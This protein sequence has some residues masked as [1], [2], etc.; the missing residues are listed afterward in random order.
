MDPLTEPARALAFTC[1]MPVWN[2]DDPDHFRAALDSLTRS[3]LRPTEVLIAVDGELAP[4][5][6]DVVREAQGAGARVSAN[7]GPRGLHHNLNQA[8]AGVRTPW[9]ARFDADDLNMP[10]R[11]QRQTDFLIDHP[12]VAVLG[13]AIVEFDE[14]GRDRIKAMPLSHEAIVRQARWRNPINHMSAFFR[15]GAVLDAGGYPALPRKE[16]YAL[17]LVLIARGERLANLVEPLVRARLG[18]NFHG[19][20][21]GLHNLSSEYALFRRKRRIA[22]IGAGP[23]LAALAALALRAGLLAFEGPAALVY[24]RALRR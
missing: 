9:V 14:A 17:W 11:F 6:A 15:T 2:G 1:L 13:G 20:R 22:G 19:R 8:L 7:G 16:D 21:A 24:E 18:P 4:P 12:E 3:S 10:D 5:L 23:A